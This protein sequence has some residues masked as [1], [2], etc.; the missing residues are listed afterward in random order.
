MNILHLKYVIEIAKAG[1]ITKAADNLFMGQPNLSKAV[2]E[3]EESL[4]ITIFRR[5]S[6]GVIPTAKG[7]QLLKHAR[8]ILAQVEEMEALA[9]QKHSERQSFHISIPRSSYVADA[10][11]R[12][13]W[14]LDRRREMQV[15]ILE[16]DGLSAIERVAQGDCN[17]SVIRYQS[18]YENYYLDYLKD[19][20]IVIDPVLSSEYYL[21]IPAR[22]PLASKEAIAPCD[23]LRY[24]EISQGE[25]NVPYVSQCRKPEC[26]NEQGKQRQLY[27]YDRMTQL[28]LLSAHIDF[29]MWSAPV[30]K[31]LL[32]KYNLTQ[33]PCSDSE[34]SFKDAL[35]YAKGYDFDYLDKLFMDELFQARD[36][37]MANITF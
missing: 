30:P 4:G 10:F 28:E 3:L 35:V 24:I 19:R 5:T 32:E 29:Y 1:S 2:R 8:S 27:V 14:R 13:V 33:Q 16:T 18:Q 6:K 17:I 11:E 9:D 20:E 25:D 21:L 12:F 15:S 37:L 31:R 34:H 22:S 7:E 23:L 26:A 36:E